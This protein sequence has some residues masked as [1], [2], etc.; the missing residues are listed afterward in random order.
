MKKHSIR[1]LSI[2]AAIASGALLLTSAAAFA[3]D[4][5]SWDKTFP[6][7]A[8][9]THQKVSFNNRLG[10]TLVADLYLPKNL[11]RS[12]KHPA[13]V[14]GGPYGAVKEQ[15]A[16]LYA[17]AMAERGFVTIARRCGTAAHSYD[18]NHRGGMK[19]HYPHQP[20]WRVAV[21]ETRDSA[22]A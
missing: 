6:Q 11:D 5:L 22:D 1:S 16:G 13:I 15:S 8:K 12:K 2:P 10:I 21:H 9:V 4:S 18:R 14:V 7:S 20:P 17:Q 3:A 19:P